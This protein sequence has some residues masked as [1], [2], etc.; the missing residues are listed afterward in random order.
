MLCYDIEVPKIADFLTK[1]VVDSTCLKSLD[2]K[3]TSVDSQCTSRINQR[4]NFK[5]FHKRDVY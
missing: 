4:L 3:K 2:P 5:Y 1:S